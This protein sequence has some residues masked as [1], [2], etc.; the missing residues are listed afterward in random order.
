MQKD[1]NRPIVVQQHAAGGSRSLT[2]Y[3]APGETFADEAQM[4]VRASTATDA[5]RDARMGWRRRESAGVMSWMAGRACEA[6]VTTLSLSHAPA[7][8]P[9]PLSILHPRLPSHPRCLLLFPF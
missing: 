5:C 9:P 7:P 6:P 1:A 8:Q 2:C 4:K 3:T